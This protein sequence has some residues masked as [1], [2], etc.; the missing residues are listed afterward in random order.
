VIEDD[1]SVAELLTTALGARDHTVV[2]TRSGEAGLRAIRSVEPDVVLLDLGLPDM[3][4]LEVCAA[5]RERSAVPILVLTADGDTDRKVRAFGLGADDYVTKP[6]ATPELMARIEVAERHHRA[7]MAA[8]GSPA[9]GAPGPA[10]AE[11]VEV[12]DLTVDPEAQLVSVAGLPLHLTHTEYRLIA[13]L[14]RRPG[15]LVTHEVILEELWPSGGGTLESLR[16]HVRNLRRKMPDDAG[17]EVRTEPGI[18][19]RLVPTRP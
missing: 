15:G 12:G 13:L 9:P 19:Y 8:N 18:G 1:P 2:V 10:P 4:G 14:A 3:D 7:A 11:P 16:V 6:F 17:A 5:I